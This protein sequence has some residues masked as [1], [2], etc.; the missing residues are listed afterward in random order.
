MSIDPNPRP[1]TTPAGTTAPTT[2]SSTAAHAAPAETVVATPSRRDV[3]TAEKE[4]AGGVKIGSA[5]FG[6]L[7]ATGMAVLLTALVAA[8]GTAVG[9]ATDTSLAEAADQ[10]ASD[11]STVG[12]TGGIALLVILFLSYCSG[13]YVAGRMARFHGMRQGIAVWGVAVVVA[14]VVAVLAAVAGD[15]YD[16]L[17]QLNAFPRLPVGNGDLTTTAVVVAVAVAG[18]AL[19]GS[20]L[21]GLAGMRFH[22]KVDKAGLGA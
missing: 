14:V 10:A 13:G 4:R 2:T 9:L 20:V 21:G 11:P 19:I 8:A 12:W 22:R 7:T 18:V 6:W 5:F 16:V 3:L 17:G 15:Q 1:T